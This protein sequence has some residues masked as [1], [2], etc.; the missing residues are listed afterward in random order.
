[1]NNNEIIKK[2]NDVLDKISVKTE[3]LESFNI[4]I[5]DKLCS[6]EDYKNKEIALEL[7][8]AR[9]NIAE[10]KILSYCISD[11]ITEIDSDI[12]CIYELI[13]ELD[14]NVSNN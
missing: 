10:Y 6:I 4:L 14:L 12:N 3:K 8:N 9:R 5:S 2:I 1:M 11:K 13:Q 7:Y